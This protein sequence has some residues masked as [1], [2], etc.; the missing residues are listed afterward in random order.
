MITLIKRRIKSMRRIKDKM[1]LSILPSLA[2]LLLGLTIIIACYNYFT[3][4]ESLL[5]RN[6]L[7]AK[8]YANQVDSF[9]NRYNAIA[10]TLSYAEMNS[11][12][13]SRKE[14]LKLLKKIAEEDKSILGSWVIYEP[15]L[16]DNLD[17]SFANTT[18]HDKTGRFLPYWNRL[19]GDLVLEPVADVETSEFYTIPKK[20]KEAFIPTP[21]IYEGVLMMS[22]CYPIMKEKLFQGVAGLDIS[23]ETVKN[24]LK[25]FEGKKVYKS[26]YV[27]L[28]SD[29]GTL[30]STSN[31]LFEKSILE[32]KT[33]N[34][35]SVEQKVPE[36]DLLIKE[37]QAGK[38]GYI[39]TKDPFTKE[40]VVAFY[41]PIKT[42]NLSIVVS[43]SRSDLLANTIKGIIILVLIGI[44]SLVIIGYIIYR[45]INSIIDP[46]NTLTETVVQF[47][48]QD[49]TSRSTVVTNDEIGELSK[50]FNSMANS[51]EDYSTEMEKKVNLRTIELNNTLQEVTKLKY[52]Q[53]GDYFLTSL[54]LNPFSKKIIDSDK[55][56]IDFLIEQKKTFEFKQKKL[57]IGGDLCYTD[58]IHLN[59]KKFIMFLNGDAM[60]KSLQG[61]GGALILGSVL[62]TIIERN[63]S[64]SDSQNVSPERWLKNSFIELHKTFETFEGLM[65]VSVVIGLIDDDTGTMYY[66]NAEHPFTILYRDGCASFIEDALQLRKLGTPMLDGKLFIKVFQLKPHDVILIGSDGKDD[67]VIN[68]ES[69]DSRTI[70]E[71]EKLILKVIEESKGEISSIK[72]NLVSYGELMDDLSILRIE[73]IGVEIAEEKETPKIN[74]STRAQAIETL[75]SM[76]AKE[77]SSIMIKHLIKLYLKD[78]NYEKA[79]FQLKALITLTP[80]DTQVLYIASYC[81]MKLN[82]YSESIEFS[83][84]CLLRE[85]LNSNY[86]DLLNKVKAKKLDPKSKLNIENSGLENKF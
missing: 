15:K 65:L 23:I 83:E 21:F 74:V 78:G 29:N 32:K 42:G 76:V 69:M 68:K 52:Q 33:I 80:S 44:A 3:E 9:I 24:L 59:N 60:G 5:N 39:K 58:S 8:S 64:N 28:V 10:Q 16:F 13:H 7:T 37:I 41:S 61:A 53:D 11:E 46:L 50:N 56:K 27:I 30:I 62:R 73:H 12:N 48:K 55:F 20:T 63:K 17:S 34:Q 54:L 31:P 84:R 57:S 47:G 45:L 14:V 1:M 25:G 26:N 6:L 71:D 36:Y 4:Q 22:F 35:I 79:Y 67:L 75:E 81:A 51:I 18:G 72:Q 49:F 82:R 77:S 40:N 70:N 43:I 19:K 85:P 86:L 38:E 66:I 2:I